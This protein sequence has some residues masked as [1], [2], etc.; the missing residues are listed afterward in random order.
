M[1]TVL[2]TGATGFVGSHTLA[3][4]S[5]VAGVRLV[6]ACRN[7][8]RLKYPFAG[9]VRQGDLRDEAYLSTL[10]NDV[11][12][13]V[14]CMA[15]SSL[16]GMQAESEA[17][18]LKPGLNLIDAFMKSHATRFVNISSTSAAAPEH[19]A[20]AMSEGIERPFWPHLC[21]VI[22][23]EN[24]LRTKL[25]LGS[26]G[27]QVVNLRLG[28][29]AGE[30]YSLGLLP[31]LVPRMKTHLVPWVAG[32]RTAMPIVDGRDI[33]Q[34]MM[35][36]ALADGIEGYQGFN[37]VGPEVPSAR[38]V[39]EFIA[40]EYGLPKPHFGVPFSM[41]YPFAWLM[42]KLDKV[43][44]W[45]PLIVRSIIHL[46]EETG[47]DNRRAEEVLGYQPEHHWKEA[48]RAQMVEM[49]QR[50]KKPMKMVMPIA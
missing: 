8:D 33:G 1:K 49:G 47:A 34:A 19:S 17:L 2:V 18:F 43:V 37:V 23:M 48:I 22:R 36:A 30:H 40:D 38:E 31:I 39:I 9:E 14:N 46:L 29:F 45:E 41:A 13:V 35:R 12:V 27:K 50:Q 25:R 16:W 15:W 4:L 7:A 10:L 42:E 26:H 11:D 21:N 28:L 24:A 32:G 44:P 6:A 20:D 3:A 5:R